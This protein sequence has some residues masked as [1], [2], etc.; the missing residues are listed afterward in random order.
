M[1]AKVRKD[2]RYTQ[3]DCISTKIVKAVLFKI[4]SVTDVEQFAK[5]LVEE[6]SNFHP[7]DDF[8]KFVNCKTDEPTYTLEEAELR[9]S[10]MEQCFEV[11]EKDKQDIYAVMHRI[12]LVETGWDK[13][14]PLPA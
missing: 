6:G 4:R 13:H 8:T 10:L 9:N 2:T 14:I 5:L 3:L 1:W 7:D 12:F 11:C